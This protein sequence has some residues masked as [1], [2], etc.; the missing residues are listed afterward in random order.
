[1]TDKMSRRKVLTLTGASGIVFA[2]S[3]AFAQGLGALSGV[4]NNL[5]GGGGGA[6]AGDFSAFAATLAGA[7]NTISK[8]TQS[9]L[10]IQAEYASSVDLLNLA[11]KLKYEAG[12]LKKGDTTGTSSLKAATKLSKSAG[13]EITKKVN[14]A[15]SLSDQQKKV[16]ANGVEEHSTAIQNMWVGV[17]ETALV[18]SQVKKLGKPSIQDI[19]ALKYFKQI[20]TDAPVALNFGKVSKATY[21]AYVK[22]FEAKGVY[23]A[24]KNRKLSLQSI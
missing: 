7:I 4:M 20:A 17:L 11:E 8:Q 24:P 1:M 12:N 3:A 5:G 16:L 23:I 2:S 15:A 22:A 10:V 18:L 13:K 6:S 19:E 9:L 21:D 14:K